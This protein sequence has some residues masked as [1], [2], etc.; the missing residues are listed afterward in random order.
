M[1]KS[2]EIPNSVTSIGDFAFEGCTTLNNVKIPESV[3]S[4]GKGAFRYC[5][6]LVTIDGLRPD[7]RMDADVFTYS[8]VGMKKDTD[9]INNHNSTQSTNLQIT[10]ELHNY[11]IS[12]IKV[13]QKKRE[14]ETTAQYKARVTKENQQKKMQELLDEAIKDYTDKKKIKA[15]I[16]CQL[17]DQIFVPFK[18]TY[19]QTKPDLNRINLLPNFLYQIQVTFITFPAGFS[20]EPIIDKRRTIKCRLTRLLILYGMIIQ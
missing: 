17:N 20:M 9:N 1:L 15:F 18:I 12:R 16:L 2:I 14:F 5:S 7:I 3:I 19:F 13:W 6:A 11:I 10:Q 8:P 4:I